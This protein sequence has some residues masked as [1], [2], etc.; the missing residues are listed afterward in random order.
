MTSRARERGEQSGNVAALATV[1]DRA[2]EVE[3]VNVDLLAL[4]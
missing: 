3:S 2:S 4:A 1:A